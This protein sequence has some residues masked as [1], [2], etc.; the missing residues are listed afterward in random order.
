MKKTILLAILMASFI[1]YA[2]APRGVYAT[3]GVSQ[4]EFASKDV[5]SDPGIGFKGGL[6][7]AI[8]FHE[9]FN[10]QLEM[11]Y[12]RKTVNFKTLG[13]D[14]TTVGKSK[15]LSESI[16]VGAYFNY[17]ILK[18]DEDKFFFGPQI[19]GNVSVFGLLTPAD[20]KSA[21]DRILPY[22]LKDNSFQNESEIN[23][24]A[25]IGITGGYN[26]FK[27]DLRYTKGL[28][29]RLAHT[30]IDSYDENNRYT[31]PALNGKL[32]SIS[33][34]FSYLFYQRIKRR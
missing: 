8:G 16:D 17:Y 23:F 13:D 2:Q 31:G 20:N 15:Y 27:F 10:Y 11:H 32:N 21:Q 12:N 33:L 18:P 1:T 5:L 34:S 30:E 26:R 4:S 3:L 6:T 24:D 29:N 14:Y 19:G 28:N 25:G 22:L 9:T 7:A